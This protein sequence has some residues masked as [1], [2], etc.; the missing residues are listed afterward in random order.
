MAILL[1]DADSQTNVAMKGVRPQQKLES[2]SKRS[3]L[4]MT[5]EIWE[6]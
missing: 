4:P 3:L 2:P 5:P 1:T 6:L